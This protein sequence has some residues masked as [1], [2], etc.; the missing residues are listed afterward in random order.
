MKPYALIAAGD[1]RQA[2]HYQQALRSAG[3]Q[4]QT[5]T[6]AA[7]AQIQLAFS[8]PDLIVLDMLLPDLPGEVVLRQIDAQRRFDSSTLILLSIEKTSTR[9]IERQAPAHAFNQP[10]NSAKLVSLVSEMSPAGA[11]L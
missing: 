5:V 2:R 9:K 7:R 3:F 8:T 10:I 6:T 4:V 1:P 11:Q